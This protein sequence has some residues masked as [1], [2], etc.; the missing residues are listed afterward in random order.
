MKKTILILTSL[1]ISLLLFGCTG[2]TLPTCN[3][4]DF[5][6]WFENEENCPSDC[7]AI[8]D[9]DAGF[10]EDGQFKD[11]DKDGCHAGTDS[12]CGGI[13]GVDNPTITCFNGID[14]D[15]DGLTDKQDNDETCS[16]LTCTSL[17]GNPC[18]DFQVCDGEIFANSEDTSRCCFGEC[19]L[20]E[21]F[22]WRNRHNENWNSPIKDQGI[23]ASCT[24]FSPIATIEAGINLY[25]NQKLDIDLAEQATSS[26]SQEIYSNCIIDLENIPEPG[27]PPNCQI[28][29]QGSTVWQGAPAGNCF[30]INAP[31]VD[32]CRASFVGIPEES[33]IPY[34]N[35]SSTHFG[36]CEERLCA[37]YDSELWKVTG[38]DQLLSQD[39][40]ISGW[41]LEN[42]PELNQTLINEE[43]LKQTIILTGP[44]AAN[45]FIEG[46]SISIVGWTDTNWI[47][48]NSWS[49]DW[50]EKG[51]GYVQK[52]DFNEGVSVGYILYPIIP[53]TPTLEINCVDKDEDLFCNWGISDEKPETC[54]DSCKEDKD[55]DDSNPNIGALGKY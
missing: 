18:A 9:C 35:D 25:Y 37:E 23:V 21:S 45:G 50:G 34:V 44:V 14:D 7:G 26:C 11:T 51:Y 55:W 27:F 52:N 42:Y 32:L 38:F 40:I 46:H 22:D 48:K 31:S 8:E 20:P 28:N 15:C 54:P 6:D 13:E 3:N 41:S 4:N 47:Y 30:G 5:C 19:K 53:P 2:Q 12:D 16:D 36:H 1:L 49:E 29:E 39:Y 10:T 43:L 17:N 24:T 33:C